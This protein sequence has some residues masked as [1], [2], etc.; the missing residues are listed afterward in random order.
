[1]K[2]FQWAAAILLVALAQ[3]VHADSISNFNITGVTVVVLPNEGGDNVF[4]TLTGPGTNISGNG[5]INCLSHWCDAFNTL[6]PGQSVFPNIGQIF[7]ANFNNA[8]V[9]GKSYPPEEELGFTSA[10]SINVLGTFT[11]PVNPNSSTFSSCVPATVSG[12]IAGFVGSGETFKQINL[13]TPAGGSFCTAWNFSGGQYQF[14]RGNFF[15][16][17]VP[18]PG[19]LGLVGSGLIALVGTAR[20]RRLQ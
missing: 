10:F 19:T 8:M 14:A 6:S 4:F 3:C 20:R 11:L 13:I 1:M 16:S 12:P 18:E 17:T 15:V 2:R 7:L 9:G 5:G